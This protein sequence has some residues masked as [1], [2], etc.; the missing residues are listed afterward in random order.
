MLKID[1]NTLVHNTKGAFTLKEAIAQI[2]AYITEDPEAQYEISIGSDSMTRASTTF[3]FAITVHRLH[4][5]GIFFYRRL[6]H[7]KITDL[8]YKL[9]QETQI[10]LDVA[11]LITKEFPEEDYSNIIWSVH[12]DI[13]KSGPTR[14]LIQE[15]EGWVTASGYNCEIKPDSYAASYIADKYSK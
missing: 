1:E 13:G 7:D 3:V 5:G 9:E 2:K 15:L 4:R 14:N 6:E 12:L 8:R 11:D 10:S